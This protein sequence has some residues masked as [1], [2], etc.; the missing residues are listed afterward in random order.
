M[1][2]TAD[3]PRTR[4]RLDPDAVKAA[5]ESASSQ[6]DYLIALYRM[7]FPDWDAVEFIERWPAVNDRTWKAI[8]TLA[9]AWDQKHA[10]GYLAGGAWLNNG[11][12]TATLPDWVADT[13]TCRVT[14]K[15]AA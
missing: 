2:A 1:A 9:M 15:K 11:F 6:E 3:K 4:V 8:C 7:V 12:T 10:P 13:S 14:Y 5:F